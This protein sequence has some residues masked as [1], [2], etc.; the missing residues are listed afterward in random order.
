MVAEQVVRRKADRCAA[1]VH[2]RVAQDRRSLAVGHVEESP[3]G[4][5]SHPDGGDPPCDLVAVLERLGL[6]V[7]VVEQRPAA[8]ADHAVERLAEPLGL[9]A[10]PAV[11]EQDLLRPDVERLEPRHAVLGHDRVDERS[12]RLDVVGVHRRAHLGVAADPV[13]DARPHALHRQPAGAPL[14]PP[15]AS[16]RRRP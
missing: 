13:V 3:S 11:G 8:D 10:V 7:L 4:S 15:G 2:E 16:G 9:A 12:R 6:E 5:A 14:A 1:G